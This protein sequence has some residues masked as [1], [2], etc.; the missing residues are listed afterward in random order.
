MK[1]YLLAGLLC[2]GI[3]GLAQ[4]PKKNVPATL[5]SLAGGPYA[6]ASTLG[7]TANNTSVDTTYLSS[8]DFSGTGTIADPIRIR[9]SVIQTWLQS[10]PGF[11]AGGGKY[12]ASDFTWKAISASTSLPQLAAPSLTGMVISSSAISLRWTDVA[13]ETGYLLQRSNDNASWTTIANTG[14]NTSQFTNNG[15]APST[16]YYYRVKALGDNTS[17]TDSPFGWDSKTT[18]SGAAVN[19]PETIFFDVANAYQVQQHPDGPGIYYSSQGNGIAQAV[20]KLPAGSDGIVYFQYVAGMG[21]LISVGYTPNNL[22][23]GYEHWTGGFILMDAELKAYGYNG[24]TTGLGIAPVNNNYYG[25]R[26]NG[27][28]IEIVTSANGITWTVLGYANYSPDD[29]YIQVYFQIPTTKVKIMG[30]NL[31]SY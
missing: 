1:Y 3:S 17:Y 31:V 8:T 5:P 22:L 4:A 21:E 24:S 11:A 30:Q 29:L 23:Q 25:F 28:S 7:T 13:N 15:L 19:T 20:K 26:R 27:S 2:A 16:T 10:L 18:S 12:L 9:T 14:A 6:L